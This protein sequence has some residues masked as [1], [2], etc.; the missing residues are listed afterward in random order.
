MSDALDHTLDRADA[1]TQECL[2]RFAYVTH[3]DLRVR[4]VRNALV[5]PR[6]YGPDRGYTGAAYDATGALVPETLRFNQGDI[7]PVDPPTLPA[8][9][10]EAAATRRTLGIYAGPL[11]PIMGH[12][13]FETLARLWPLAHLGSGG[14]GTEPAD[15]V[16]HHWPGLELPGFFDNPLYRELL[17]TLG[18]TPGRLVLA[19]RPLSY[20]TLLVADPASRYHVDLNVQMG[21]LLMFTRRT[22][23]GTDTPP[24]TGDRLY[25][26]R[27]R[28]GANRRILNEA[29]IDES[30]AARG[31]QVVY[32]ETLAPADLV[33]IM[34]GASIVVSFDGS[35]AHLAAF[36]EPDTATVLFD[37]RPVPTQI[38]IA[39]L[40]G[41][42]IMHV[43]LFELPELYRADAGILDVPGLCSVA[44]QAIRERLI[45]A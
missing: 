45:A 24:L 42:R 1:F 6:S 5:T 43:P 23:L 28:W 38:A 18:I 9:L 36:C 30:M 32:P 19:D 33:G 21:D 7:N 31:Y 35:H 25:L 40:R 15:I 14:D 27:S 12:F 2:G 20:D 41:F 34:A 22:L 37:T 44:E 3:N 8:G 39:K 17:G 10:R 16:V 11:F 26:S 29:E 13:M 4:A